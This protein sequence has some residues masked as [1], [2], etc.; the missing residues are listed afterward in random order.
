MEVRSMYF[1]ARVA[2]KLDDPV[3]Q[4]RLKATKGKFVD[5]RAKSIKELPEFEATRDAAQ[6]TQCV[7]SSR[8]TAVGQGGKDWRANGIGQKE[9]TAR[10][11]GL[12]RAGEP[13]DI[14]FAPDGSL[15]DVFSPP[16]H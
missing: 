2:Q 4:A 10:H 3:L 14:S 13:H 5:K 6:S 1:K 11:P 12:A 15:I 8:P 9:C 16:A 7:E